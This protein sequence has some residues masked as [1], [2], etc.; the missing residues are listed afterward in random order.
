MFGT[1]LACLTQHNAAGVNTILKVAF[2]RRSGI[3]S[4]SSP[5]PHPPFV[6]LS[7]PKDLG[8]RA[9]REILRQAQDDRDPP[10]SHNR[11]HIMLR[12]LVPAPR[13]KGLT[14]IHAT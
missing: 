3:A 14:G 10:S 6:I 13:R 5:R 9:V 11:I 2:F 7:L 12:K 8:D 4:T 1:S